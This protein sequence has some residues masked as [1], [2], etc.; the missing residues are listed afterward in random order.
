MQETE[1][2]TDR[3]ANNDNQSEDQPSN[4]EMPDLIQTMLGIPIAVFVAV[5]GVEE[6]PCVPVT[7]AR[8]SPLAE[9]IVDRQQEETTPE[10]I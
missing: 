9:H 8:T 7:L 4:Q 2:G 5:K 1:T 10:Q 6:R 3:C